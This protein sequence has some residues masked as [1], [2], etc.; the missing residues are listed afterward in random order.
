MR[1]DTEKLTISTLIEFIGKEIRQYKADN[2]TLSIDPSMLKLKMG[3]LL[4]NRLWSILPCGEVSAFRGVVV[5][6]ALDLD[7]DEMVLIV[8]SNRITNE[9]EENTGADN[10]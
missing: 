8:H 10:F 4:Y 9:T 6:L 3:W 5:E 1:I 7:I 2:P